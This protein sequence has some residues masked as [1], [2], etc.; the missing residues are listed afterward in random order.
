MGWAD[1]VALQ[2]QWRALPSGVLQDWP[3]GTHL[4][5]E[6]LAVLMISISD[7]TAADALAG[8]VGCAEVEQVAPRACVRSS[9]RGRR[10]C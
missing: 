3:L 2:E 6:S 8:L 9:P 1:V 5:V 10:S 7:N 4:T